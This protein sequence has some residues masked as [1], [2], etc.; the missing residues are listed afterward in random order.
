VES[1][2]GQVVASTLKLRSKVWLKRIVARAMPTTPRGL[3]FSAKFSVKRVKHAQIFPHL[4]V[5][6]TESLPEYPVI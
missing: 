3:A 1:L 2:H 6:V 5:N 4:Q